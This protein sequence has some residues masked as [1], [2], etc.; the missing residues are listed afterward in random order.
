MVPSWKRDVWIL[1]VRCV[2]GN[3]YRARI[4]AMA[5]GDAFPVE[6]NRTD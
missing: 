5:K 2:G 3:V 4:D 6:Q 1:V